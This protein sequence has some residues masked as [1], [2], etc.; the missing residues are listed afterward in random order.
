[1]KGNKRVGGHLWGEQV[2]TVAGT[3]SHNLR[4]IEKLT[5][6]VS[7]FITFHE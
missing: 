4:F 7:S 2:E 6:S 1:M 3:V 5:L